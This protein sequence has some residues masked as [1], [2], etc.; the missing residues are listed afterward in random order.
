MLRR[1]SYLA[2]AA[3]IASIVAVAGTGNRAY[4]ATLVPLPPGGYSRWY[5]STRYTIQFR[6]ARRYLCMHSLYTKA[7]N[8][9]K[10]CRS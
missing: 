2:M 4:A 10:A 1:A 6:A 3:V 5:S 7:D 9:Y 8:R